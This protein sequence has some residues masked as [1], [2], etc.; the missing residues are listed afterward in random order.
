MCVLSAKVPPVI[1][2]TAPKIVPSAPPCF[3]E[4]S[5]YS[6]PAIANVPPETKIAPPAVVTVFLLNVPLAIDNVESIA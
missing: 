1:V 3:A 4:F 2:V 5:V 6:P